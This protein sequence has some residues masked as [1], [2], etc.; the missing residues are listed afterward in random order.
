[1]T[2]TDAEKRD[3][4]IR[5]STVLKG[6]NQ[7]PRD[8]TSLRSAASKLSKPTIFA[9]DTAADTAVRSRHGCLYRLAHLMYRKWLM[10]RKGNR[11]SDQFSN[12]SV[13][14]Q[15]LSVTLE[16]CRTDLPTWF[17]ELIRWHEP[18]GL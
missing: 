10:M 17:A 14:R 16:N 13:A 9:A 18:N 2:E 15:G 6:S 7:E 4:A 12:K 11:R 1:V 8:R 3:A 5:L